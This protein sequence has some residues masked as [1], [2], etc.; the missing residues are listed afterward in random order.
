MKVSVSKRSSCRR[1]SG[2]T[3]V[4]SPHIDYLDGVSFGKTE[5]RRSGCVHDEVG[6]V[7]KVGCEDRVS[8]IH[9]TTPHSSF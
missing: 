8:V 9:V 1:V 5:Q 7:D 2:R 6:G 3:D 4:R